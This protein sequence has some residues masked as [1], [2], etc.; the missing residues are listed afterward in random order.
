[1]TGSPK[2]CGS[3]PCTQQQ[4]RRLCNLLRSLGPPC[5]QISDG[6]VLIPATFRLS[7]YS[8]ISLGE[9]VHQVSPGVE[10]SED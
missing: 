3:Q 1:M 4:E 9:G 6:M 2:S 8:L 5:L 10:V 7:R